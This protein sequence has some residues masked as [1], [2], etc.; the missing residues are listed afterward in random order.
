[1]SD[2][3]MTT[4]AKHPRR[5]SP[6]RALLWKEWRQ[7]RGIFLGMAW[8]A[9]VMLLASRWSKE[10]DLA[11]TAGGFIASYC[12]TILLGTNAFNIE[13]D[14]R[15]HHFLTAHP[16]GLRH[17]FIV[18]AMIA[19]CLTLLAQIVPIALLVWGQWTKELVG[20]K[21][22]LYAAMV[23]CH[24]LIVFLP[25]LVTQWASSAMACTLASLGAAALVFGS[26]GAGAF[27]FG[28]WHNISLWG[29]FNPPALAA[30]A[31]CMCGLAVLAPVLCYQW[32][33]AQAKGIIKAMSKSMVILILTLAGAFVPIAIELF[34][35]TQLM[36]PADW[37]RTPKVQMRTVAIS[38]DRSRLLLTA[39]DWRNTRTRS[40]P[41]ALPAILVDV[42]TGKA[43]WATQN[44][45]WEGRRRLNSKSNY[46]FK[47]ECNWTLGQQ[48][49][50]DLFR[51]VYNREFRMNAATFHASLRPTVFM[52]LS[53]LSKSVPLTG[54]AKVIEK[55][56]MPG[57]W[58]DETIVVRTKDG[59]HFINIVTNTDA[60]CQT[61]EAWQPKPNTI[62]SGQPRI[63]PSMVISLCQANLREG[64]KPV[65]LQY[66]PE[67]P[68]AKV[69]ETGINAWFQAYNQALPPA[70]RGKLDNIRLSGRGNPT[71]EWVRIVIYGSGETGTNRS[72][73]RSDVEHSAL[74]SLRSGKMIHM[75][76]QVMHGTRYGGSLGSEWIVNDWCEILKRGPLCL[77]KGKFAI[78]DPQASTLGPP[79]HTANPDWLPHPWQANPSG[80]RILIMSVLT[81]PNEGEWVWQVWDDTTRT[82]HTLNP[83]SDPKIRLAHW[84]DEDRIVLTGQWQ[85]NNIFTINYDGTG[86]RPLLR[87]EAQQ[88]E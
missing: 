88:V 62:S 5:P 14:Q 13:A 24:L 75:N 40:L 39:I 42:H 64:R 44:P 72:N 7:Q 2:T 80:N 61:P 23:G 43:V 73:E 11:L 71:G 1:M 79:V 63:R 28:Q 59:L 32:R 6:L 76:S 85:G 21:E 19:V 74:L 78:F 77:A 3:T 65:L 27:A 4:T 58:D 60:F 17:V 9:P 47:S 25:A 68:K 86:L 54:K 49:L 8:I 87:R 35:I 33:P 18:K 22:A 56:L 83:K 82:L 10:F 26:I 46:T 67:W 29:L 81:D 36:T 52:D 45:A 53:D 69:M 15:T 12:V 38:K 41:Q 55:Y 37:A 48:Y 31:V 50:N 34:W 51:E 30:T 84:I 16:L 66:H 70:Q 57:W 20:N